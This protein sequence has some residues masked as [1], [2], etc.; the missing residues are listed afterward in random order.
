MTRNN[1][2]FAEQERGKDEKHGSLVHCGQELKRFKGVELRG[3]SCEQKAPIFCLD[4]VIISQ[5]AMTLTSMHPLP[6][7]IMGNQPR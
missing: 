5:E 7:H 3:I 4:T 2:S 6:G 1:A